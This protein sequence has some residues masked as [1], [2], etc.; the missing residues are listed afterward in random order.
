MT[1]D[2]KIRDENLQYNIKREGARILAL[3]SSKNDKYD[4]FTGEKVL[5]SDQSRIREQANLTKS[6]L[7]KVFEKQIKAIEDQG[8]KQGEALKSLKS[9]E[10]KHYKKSIDEVFRKEMRT[11]KI[12]NEID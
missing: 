2:D 12:K 1:V 3:S 7:I 11:N 9:E 10:N 5:Q 8:I 6:L 4:F